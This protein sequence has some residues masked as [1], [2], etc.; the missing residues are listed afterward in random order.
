MARFTPKFGLDS[1]MLIT[2]LTAACSAVIQASPI[3]GV[4]L[5]IVAA[6]ALVQTIIQIAMRQTEQRRMPVF[7]K[8]I[9]FFMSLA[10]VLVSGGPAFLSF[11]LVAAI[12]T[13]YGIRPFA[14]F[15]AAIVAAGAT[16]Y[17]GYRLGSQVI[18]EWQQ[19]AATPPQRRQKNIHY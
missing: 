2:A 13:G 7:D 10:I 12:C 17:V 1:L 9:T 3:L 5:A 19:S 15:A 4:P 18:Q 8:V 16:G 6:S 11:V 14:G